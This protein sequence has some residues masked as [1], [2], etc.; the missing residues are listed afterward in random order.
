MITAAKHVTEEGDRELTLR[1]NLSS[2]TFSHASTHV[3]L[4][5]D[6]SQK[7]AGQRELLSA[8]SKGS[9]LTHVEVLQGRS[10]R[11]THVVVAR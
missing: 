2:P 11:Q 5:R 6:L 4:R 7:F 1:Q 8:K 3:R 9:K 10:E